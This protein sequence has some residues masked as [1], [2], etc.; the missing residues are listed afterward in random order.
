MELHE[1]ELRRI[2]LTLVAPFRTPFGTETERDILLLRAVTSEGEGW[3]ECVALPE[4]SYSSEYV[5]GAQ[6]VLERCL[7]PRLF[8]CGAFD[9]GA[10]GTI[11]SPVKGHRMAKAALEMA[12][13]D[14]Y[15]RHAGVSFASYLGGVRDEV[16]VGVS[17][18]I[19]ASI[20]ELLD[21]VSGYVEQ[22]YRRIKLKIEPGWDLEPVGAVRNGFDAA[23]LLQVD[24]NAAYTLDDA[25]HL[26]HLD[27]F[28]LLLLEQPLAEDDLVGHASL[29]RRIATPICLDE[30]I[31]SANDAEAAIA[32]GWDPLESTCRHASLSIL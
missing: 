2:T 9:V 19:M 17:I 6:E 30:S 23:L 7:V 25:A 29:A 22:G 14:A 16:E 12:V 24:A 1:V 10:V 8:A 32:L 28:D 31:E 4:P 3:G 11:L 21:A 20:A 26:A 5:D 18:G 15:L 13:L 27:A